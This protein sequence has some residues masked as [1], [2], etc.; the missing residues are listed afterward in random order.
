MGACM[1]IVCPLAQLSHILFRFGWIVHHQAY[2]QTLRRLT[3]VSTH[4]SSGLFLSACVSTCLVIWLRG[5]SEKKNGDFSL[6]KTLPLEN[7]TLF[8][9][10]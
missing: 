7:V 5:V 6:S 3:Y 2:T 9:A 4:V 8:G 10:E 1:I